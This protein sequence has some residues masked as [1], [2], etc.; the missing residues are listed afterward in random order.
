MLPDGSVIENMPLTCQRL[1]QA[2]HDMTLSR[3]LG[4]SEVSCNCPWPIEQVVNIGLSFNHLA[5]VDHC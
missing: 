2:W 5:I 1:A 4:V 3:L